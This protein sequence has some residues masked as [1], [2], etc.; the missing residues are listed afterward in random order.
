[1]LAALAVV[2]LSARTTLAQDPAYSFTMAPVSSQG[3][4]SL[5][6]VF[7]TNAEITVTSLGYYDDTQTGF[8]TGHTV[9]IFDQVGTLLV[10]TTLEPGNVETLDGKFRYK[11]I[12]PTTLAAGSTYTAAATTGG[13]ADPFAYGVRGSSIDLDVHPAITIDNAAARF[14]YQSEDELRWP[15][16]ELGYT[17]Y[18]GPNFKVVSTPPP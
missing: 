2:L 15:T 9:G 13:P 14:L 10:W 1:M 12:E 11:E 8:A 6:F 7:T 5:G 3:F 17:M 18:A 4:I 16:G